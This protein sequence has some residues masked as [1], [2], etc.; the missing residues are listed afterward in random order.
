MSGKEPSNRALVIAAVA[1]VIAILFLFIALLNSELVQGLSVGS[2]K[3]WFGLDTD[4][5]IPS[6]EELSRKVAEDMETE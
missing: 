3:E 4:N 6:F 2:V 1:V 5:P